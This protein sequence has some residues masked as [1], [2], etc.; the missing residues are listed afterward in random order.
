MN[1]AKLFTQLTK[2]D[3]LWFCLDTSSDTGWK[4]LGVE[5]TA[6]NEIFPRTSPRMTLLQTRLSYCNHLILVQ[7]C[8]LILSSWGV[9]EAQMIPGVK[10]HIQWSGI[11]WVT[12]GFL[13]CDGGGGGRSLVGGRG[14]FVGGGGGG[15][16]GRLF[17][18]GGG[19]AP[20]VVGWLTVLT[21]GGGG[22]LSCPF[23]IL[24][25]S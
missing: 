15:C 10:K 23:R 18:G 4:V 6:L 11:L 21:G 20:R 19:G 16:D 1:H 13:T 7:L 5:G 8:W 9:W 24:L 14:G 12:F 25:S 3:Y 22:L 17:V 2:G